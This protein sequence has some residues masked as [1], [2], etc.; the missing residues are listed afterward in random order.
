MHVQR[1]QDNR[2]LSLKQQTTKTSPV[3]LFVNGLM[4]MQKNE[5][6][7]NNQPKVIGTV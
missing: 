4:A 5:T 3:S 2:G 7:H 1:R 6:M